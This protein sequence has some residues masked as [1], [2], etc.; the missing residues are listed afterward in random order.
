MIGRMRESGHTKLAEIEG[1]RAVA[2]I[3]VVLY[4]L[5][6]TRMAGGYIGVDVFFVVSGFLIT[7]LLLR[8]VEGFGRI[9][10]AGFWARRIRRIVP[11][12]TLVTV[13]TVVSGFVIFE[14]NQTRQLIQV[15][16]GAVG[17][18]ANLVLDSLT[19]DYLAGVVNPS[20]L[21]HY[22]SLGV[23]EQF[24]VVWPLVVFVV[25]RVA[26]NRW[27]PALFLTA[28]VA[29]SASMWA[30]VHH[31][32]PGVPSG[33]F[34]PQTRAWEILIG[35]LLAMVATIFA[36]MASDLRAALGWI[37]LTAVMIAAI[38]FDAETPFPGTA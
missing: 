10:L 31:V 23:E 36:R 6:V 5:G 21:Q 15:G 18:C 2:V 30:S 9:S 37:G 25:L 7:G 4:H 26:R 16:L 27:R 29:I 8:E 22:W 38:R 33:Y 17:F 34:L 13:A 32:Q 24:Y 12:A 28:I 3:L 19:G 11:M 20:P 35:A 14:R 1:L